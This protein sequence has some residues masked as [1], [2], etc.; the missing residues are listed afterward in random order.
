MNSRPVIP[1]TLLLT[2]LLL[3]TSPCTTHAVN[4]SS[5]GLGMTIN[6]S[7]NGY[8][9]TSTN[10]TFSGCSTYPTPPGVVTCTYDL[11][12]VPVNQVMTYTVN[13]TPTDPTVPASQHEIWVRYF[14][15]D[16]T[17]DNIVYNLSANGQFYFWVPNP[18]TGDE[19]FMITHLAVAPEFYIQVRVHYIDTPRDSVS[20][21]SHLLGGQNH[22]INTMF[23]HDARSRDRQAWPSERLEVPA[24]E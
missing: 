22:N 18:Q 3:F 4:F 6:W 1:A 13:V 17:Q 20:F 10:P 8:G 12:D 11:Y 24:P 19:V 9:I 14:A 15:G 23:L 16:T 7:L 5:S 21:L 2:V